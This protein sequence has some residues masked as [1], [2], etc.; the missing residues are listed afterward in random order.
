MGIG[1]FIA[2]AAFKFTV[3]NQTYRDAWRK[4]KL[5]SLAGFL[6]GKADRVF[7][8]LDESDE[9]V[10]LMREKILD[11]LADLVVYAGMIAERVKC[12]ESEKCI[13]GAAQ[14]V[15]ENLRR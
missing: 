2:D 4:M 9:V 1:E 11:D 13:G 15:N 8:I 6:L 5:K 7:Q 3:R 12:L 14:S 10:I